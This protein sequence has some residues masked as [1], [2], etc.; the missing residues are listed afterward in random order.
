[1]S[2]SPPNT[3]ILS[4]R[5]GQPYAE[6]FQDIYF[7]QQGGLAESEY[8]FLAQNQLAERWQAQSQDYFCIVESGFGTGL[9]FLAACRLWLNSSAAHQRLHYVACEKYPL[10]L[11]QLQQ[12]QQMWPELAAI[13]TELCAQ[14]GHLGHGF[15]RWQLFQQRVVFS[16]FVGDIA[17]FCQ[18]FYGYADAWFLDGFAPAKNP[19]MWQAN[20]FQ[21]MARQSNAGASFA[22]FTS[23]GVVKRGL[24]SA[25]FVVNKHA[26]YG[27]KREM[28]SGYLASPTA[29]REMPSR[30]P[31]PSESPTT[32]P[33]AS[34]ST[35]PIHIAII[36]AGLSGLLT[37]EAL[38]RRGYQCTV[39]EQ[40]SGAAQ[41]AS[42]NDLGV[43][44]P[45]PNEGD[46][47][48]NQLAIASYQY[49]LPFLQHLIASLPQASEMMQ[50]CGVLQVAQDAA[51]AQ[52]LRNIAQQAPP[53][54]QY[55]DAEQASQ[56][57]G[58]VLSQAALYF[59][60]AGWLN[61][62]L[63][64]L[65]LLQSLSQQYGVNSLFHQQVL[66]LQA[67]DHAANDERCH[68]WQIFAGDQCLLQADIVILAN[69]YQ[70]QHISQTAH[71][72]LTPVKGQTSQLPSNAEL[73]KLNCVLCGDAYLSPAIDLPHSQGQHI[74]GATFE[75]H[76][77]DLSVTAQG[78]QHN[79]N[80][81]AK[82]LPQIVSNLALTAHELSQL[83]GR[84]AI[85]SS[86]PDYLPLLGAILDTE[87]M[88]S[89]L[90][91]QRD[92][93]HQLPFHR[94]LYVHAGHG[95]KGILQAPLCAE[96]LACQITGEAM[97]V[98][99]QLLAALNP[100]RFW[101]KQHAFKK[102]RQQY[103]DPQIYLDSGCI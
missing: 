91:L 96:I 39:I 53:W 22:T 31:S 79:L 48:L 16:L 17:D 21:M 90:T 26:G 12:A 56:I 99:Q 81:L 55:V 13:S 88:P 10:S 72:K 36:G 100:N 30:H 64:C 68:G 66:R 95:A 93:S 2:S 7:S 61:P 41:G 102:Q 15:H 46:N 37:A 8:V 49:S 69:A 98:S 18:Q 89:A 6:I 65:A 60:S 77:S 58:V 51:Q 33:S 35:R 71:C 20:L 92:P 63:F 94:G 85:R 74:L 3:A 23:A 40:Q 78:H 29:R 11:A 25:G 57:A 75:P 5:D 24:Q 67:S 97:P 84:A 80:T 1:M 45:R 103:L 86:S 73:Q 50:L 32:S 44:Y 34:Q 38:A 43:L 28:L 62:K 14:Y 52:R 101:L 9:N 42:G 54:L 47:P 76:V 70:I 82:I 4:W 87:Q 19:D 59:P 83:S 27:K